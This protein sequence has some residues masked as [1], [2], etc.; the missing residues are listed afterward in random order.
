MATV[1]SMITNNNDN[2]TDNDD[3]EEVVKRMNKIIGAT[4]K[5]NFPGYGVWEGKVVSYVPLKNA[6]ECVY[7]DGFIEYNT[8]K[9]LIRYN[10]SKI[11]PTPITKKQKKRKLVTVLNN[12]DID[13]STPT[14][15]TMVKT[16][17]TIKEDDNSTMMMGNVKKK[18]KKK[19]M[20][21]L[22]IKNSSSTTANPKTFKENN[23]NAS[24]ISTTTLS[25]EPTTTITTT[26]NDSNDTMTFQFVRNN[27]LGLQLSERSNR[28]LGKIVY[29]SGINANS[30]ASQ[31]KYWLNTWDKQLIRVG[32]SP[33]VGLTLKQVLK[34]VA[35]E[36]AR[37]NNNSILELR[38]R[39]NKMTKNIKNKRKLQE[40]KKPK[41]EK[42]KVESKQSSKKLKR[43]KFFFRI[44]PASVPIQKIFKAPSNMHL[45]SV[46]QIECEGKN[47]S[48]AAQIISG[49]QDGDAV[50]VKVVFDSPK[51]VRHAR[52]PLNNQTVRYINANIKYSKNTPYPEQDKFILQP[53]NI[54]FPKHTVSFTTQNRGKIKSSKFDI[55][56]T[57]SAVSIS[58]FGDSWPITWLIS[59]MAKQED[60][61]HNMRSRDKNGK[62]SGSA[63]P[64]MPYR[65]GCILRHVT[66]CQR[67][68]VLVLEFHT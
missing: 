47:E 48:L 31:Y 10:V 35:A 6:F 61:A 17:A 30:Q 5:K 41:M 37:L 20:D 54:D 44:I 49:T 24:D 23:L 39:N 56:E 14:N 51:G 15:V 19:S 28:Q 68:N 67:K 3:E 63:F 9:K 38:F 64:R 11:P 18:K 32:E 36:K 34:V 43:K 57:T 58:S 53:L 46:I 29:V 33:V 8:L 45:A 65:T 55:P 7:K 1:S 27:T 16:P 12:R 2:T 22:N 21:T 42:K 40:I 62:D 52:G 66:R 4:Y 50:P 26:T 25:K 13:N 59:D 60:L